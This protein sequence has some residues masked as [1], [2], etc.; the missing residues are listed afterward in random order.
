MIRKFFENSWPYLLI[1]VLLIP[2]LWPLIT[3]GFFRSDDGEWMVIRLVAFFDTLRT[4]QF[5]VRFLW[6]LNHGFGYPVTNFLYPLPFYFGSLIHL[7]GFGFVDSIKIL[8]TLSFILGSWFMYLLV[9]KEWGKWA[10]IAAGI[11]YSYAPYRIFDVYSRGSLG[12]SVAFVFIPLIF[13]FINQKK[14]AATALSTAALICSHNVIAFLFVPIILVYL[15]IKKFP[16]ILASKYMLLAAAVAAWFWFPALYDL[17]YTR[18]SITAVSNYKDYFLNFNLLGIIVPI[19]IFTTIIRNIVVKKFNTNFA[20]IVCLVSIFFTLPISEIFWQILPL[21]KLVQFPWRFL[22][23]TIF[24]SSILIGSLI[25]N[26]KLFLAFIAVLMLTTRFT[27]D[28]IYFEDN[29]YV[30]NDGTTTVKNEYMP[31]W[32][33]FDPTQRATQKSAVYFPGIKPEV[34]NENGIVISDTVSF[35]ETNPRLIANII[36]VIAIVI[37]VVLLI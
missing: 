22:S 26:I 37:C 20:I 14:T 31:K 2:L 1:L 32:V 23:V 29:Y 11:F 16:L 18:A 4:G 7:L 17:Q 34:Y 28:K 21:P 13:Y 3:P 9:N 33:K 8:F 36:S 5:P 25:K 24:F 6:N 10:G 19:I 35:S 30:A 15:I 27:V 12:E